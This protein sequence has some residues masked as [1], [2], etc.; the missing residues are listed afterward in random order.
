MPPCKGHCPPAPEGP[1][2]RL[3]STDVHR[4]CLLSFGHG[5]FFVVAVPIESL[6]PQGLKCWVPGGRAGLLEFCRPCLT[7]PRLLF[8]DI[9][10]EQ[11]AGQE[12]AEQEPGSGAVQEAWGWC[13]PGLHCTAQ[14]G[15]EV[16]ATTGWRLYWPPC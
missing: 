10:D 15:R 4:V 3:Q 5:L 13:L 14:H 16:P 2:L 7:A 8:E 6:P 11:L 12:H 1:T 9:V